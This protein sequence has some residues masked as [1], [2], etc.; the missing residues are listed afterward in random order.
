MPI[1][2]LYVDDDVSMREIVETACCADPDFLVTTVGSGQEAL[3]LTRKTPFDLVL[4][5]VVMPGLDGPATLA[6]LRGQEE[7]RTPIAFLTAHAQPTE[8]EWLQELDVIGVL[9]K[10]FDPRTLAGLLRSL[11]DKCGSTPRRH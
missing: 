11:M 1:K 2:M 6:M 3:T 9:A 7:R 5:D 10:P 8:R 4:L